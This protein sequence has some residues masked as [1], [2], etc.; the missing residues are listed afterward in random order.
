MERRGKL[1]QFKTIYNIEFLQTYGKLKDEVQTHK[2]CKDANIK[3]INIL[4]IGEISAGKSS[5][6]NSVESVFSG[7]V[8]LRADSGFGGESVTTQVIIT[9][10]NTTNQY[11][12]VQY[13][14]YRVR[15]TD[16]RKNR[17]KFKFCDSMGL[18]GNDVGLSATDV[19]KIMDGHAEEF[20]EVLIGEIKYLCLKNIS[21]AFPWD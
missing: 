18:E 7:H 21:P 12:N 15:A 10:V 9:N 5:F 1:F 3:N 11:L 17:I 14:Q 16:K 8:T 6:F 20:A 13:R 19:G 4:L 2:L